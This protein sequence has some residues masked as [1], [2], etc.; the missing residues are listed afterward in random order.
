MRKSVVLVRRRCGLGEEEE[1]EERRRKREVSDAKGV[2]DE[3]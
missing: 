2:W 3:E 1:E